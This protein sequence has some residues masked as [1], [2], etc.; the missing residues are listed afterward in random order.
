MKRLKQTKSASSPS[1]RNQYCNNN[2]DDSMFE[3]TV[4]EEMLEKLRD[5][6]EDEDEES[7]IRLRE[8]QVGGG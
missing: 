5:M 3:L 4:P 7:C 6:L 8:Y 2:E 1:W